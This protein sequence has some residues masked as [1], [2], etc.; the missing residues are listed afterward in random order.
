MSAELA[1][2]SAASRS[3]A[4]SDL[5]TNFRYNTNFTDM[6]WMDLDSPSACVFHPLH[7]TSLFIS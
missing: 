4:A 6:Q 5:K 1:A 3:A 2:A 7:P